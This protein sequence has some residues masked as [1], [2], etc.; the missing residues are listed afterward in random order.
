MCP[1][2]D[3][4]TIKSV[5]ASQRAKSRAFIKVM[6][7]IFEIESFEQQYVIIKGLFQ[8]KQMKEIWFSLRLTNH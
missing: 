1:K 6:N 4:E 2:I 8:S 5:L 3:K 7:V